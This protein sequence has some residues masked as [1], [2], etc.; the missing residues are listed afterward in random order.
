MKLQWA[1]NSATIM[2]V[3][4]EKEL[5][6]WEQFGWKAAEIWAS[7][8]TP[9][10]DA[11]ATYG[12]LVR[13]MEDAGVAPL[14]L[15]AGSLWT[16]TEERDREFDELAKLLDMTAAMK[17][18]SLTVIILGKVQ[19]DFAADTECLVGK[20]RKASDMAAERGLAINLEF[21]AGQ[22]ANGTLGS[23][24]ELVNRVDHPAC[25][26]LFDFC[27]YYASPSHFEEMALLK[28]GKL[29]MVHVDDSQHLPMERLTSEQRCFPG[30]GRID[31]AGMIHRLRTE[32]NYDGPFSV[33][34]YDK[35][36]W[37]MDP[38]EVMSRLSA[39]LQKIEE[40]LP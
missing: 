16:A 17:A 21:L 5:K 4:W 1:F 6:L 33:E 9:Q 13:Q 19:E 31:V 2:R 27:H 25:G 40:K 18:R 14:G 37:E 30:E 3:P 34:L 29:F 28:P 36:I 20:L 35:G 11:G 12:Q 38:H 22:A 23:C 10:L 32:T 24:I 8:I 15:C 39:S 26:M 7:K